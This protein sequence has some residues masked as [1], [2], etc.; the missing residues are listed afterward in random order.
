MGRGQ[1]VV[2]AGR[3]ILNFFLAGFIGLGLS[4]FL[5]RRGWLATWISLPILVLTIIVAVALVVA[6]VARQENEEAAFLE[7]FNE[8]LFDYDA[9]Y[10]LPVSRAV[11]LLETDCS[12]IEP[13]PAVADCDAL[14][15]ALTEADAELV[16]V[17]DRLKSLQQRIPD[18]AAEEVDTILAGMIRVLELDHE[19]NE[20]L[21][22]GWY[23]QD[24]AKWQEGWELSFQAA[25]EGLDFAEDVIRIV[26]ELED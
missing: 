21:A 7:E 10:T 25:T 16:R 20:V 22:E 8:I 4:Y 11:L 2:G 23:E 3:Y 14:M 1:D 15:E 13:D 6:A 5:R 26:E 12:A 17:I 18:F 19:S 9:G 24:P